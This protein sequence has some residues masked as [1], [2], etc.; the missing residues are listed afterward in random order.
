VGEFESFSFCFICE[1]EIA[2]PL[3]RR[4]HG[5]II[6]AVFSSAAKFYVAQMKNNGIDMNLSPDSTMINIYTQ[7]CDIAN[8][9]KLYFPKLSVK[10]ELHGG[11]MGDLEATFGTRHEKCLRSLSLFLHAPLMYFVP[12][13]LNGKISCDVVL[14]LVIPSREG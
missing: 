6:C 8:N 4:L 9:E 12:F 13:R 3:W 7:G 14:A 2:Q 1:L 11:W 5:G 10:E